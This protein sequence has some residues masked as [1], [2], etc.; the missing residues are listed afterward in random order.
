MV[1]SESFMRQTSVIIAA[2]FAGFVG[3]W[4]GARLSRTAEQNRA[5]HVVRARS[6]ELVDETGK[7]ISIWGVNRQGHTLLAFLGSETVPGEKGEHSVGLDNLVNLRAAFGT[8]GV[9]PSLTFTGTDGKT[10]LMLYLGG[11]DKPLLW[12]GDETGMR[13]AL[14]NTVSD[15]PSAEDNDWALTFEPH[16]AWIGMYSRPE[17]GQRYV[18]GLLSVSKD[19]VKYP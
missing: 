7:A 13:V 11:W 17:G 12:M 14:G 5:Q 1:R 18:K 2:L 4:L 19:K 9:F 16:R 15:T 10:R 3:G 8:H 6:F